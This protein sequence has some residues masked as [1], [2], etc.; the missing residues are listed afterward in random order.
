MSQFDSIEQQD[1]HFMKMAMEMA[2]KAEERGEVP[3]G[4]VLV[5]DGEVVSAG[6]NFSI[7][8]HDPSAHAEMQCLRQAGQI[9]QNYRLL[10]T[11]LYVTLEPCAMCAGA[12]VHSRINRLVF[13]ARD[14]K[15]GAAGTV[16]DIVRH[17]AFNHQLDVSSGVL[18]TECSE[19]LSAFFKRR[20][21]EKKAAKALAKQQALL[22]T[23][24]S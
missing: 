13:G 17:S 14:E 10:D 12:I 5:K 2:T 19:Q 20:R 11:T 22:L 16:I 3:V 24:K 15:T 1:L 23:P 21:N 6:F 8:L 9:M 7:G 4:A 18:E